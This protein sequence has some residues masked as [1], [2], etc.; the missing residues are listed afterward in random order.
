[1]R[2]R[3]WVPLISAVFMMSCFTACNNSGS[4]SSSATKIALSSNGVTVEGAAIST[5]PDDPV[6]LSHDM[7]EN[8]KQETE[9]NGDESSSREEKTEVSVVNI[10]SPGTYRLFGTLEEGQ[11][12]VDLGEKAAKDPKAVVSLI[13]DNAHIG[14]SAAPAIFFEN[15]Y[16]CSGKEIQDAVSAEADTSAAGANIILA[17]G[18]INTVKG[19]GG[20]GVSESAAIFSMMS[21][22]INSEKEDYGTLNLIGDRE[23]IRSKLHLTIN[24]GNIHISAGNSGICAGTDDAAVATVNGGNLRISAGLGGEKGSGI[25]SEGWLVMNGGTVVA[26]AHSP[27]AAGFRSDLGT[28]INGGTVVALGSA[29]ECLESDSGQVTMNLQFDGEKELVGPIVVTDAE[30]NAVFAYDPRDDAV[31]SDDPRFYS[32][33]L[34]SCPALAEEELYHLYLGGTLDGTSV[35]GLYDAE[36]ITGYTGG[37]EQTFTG[38]EKGLPSGVSGDSGISEQR[39]SVSDVGP[40]QRFRDFYL[41]SRVNFFFGIN[42]K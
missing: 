5:D 14:C 2:F 6:Y 30:K 28:Y 23:G 12:R 42:G 3:K 17:D 16:E 39:T 36:T 27:D 11:I 25:D 15:V 20:T 26:A 32:G 21:I 1:M 41:G 18:S 40:S 4:T 37:A 33:A 10:T 8:Q 34:I 22:N 24:G 9:E 31:F 7:M 35:D 29:A 19:S 13:L 38:T